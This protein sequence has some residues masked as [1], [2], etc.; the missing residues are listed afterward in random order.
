[1]ILAQK[2]FEEECLRC[3]NYL[4]PSSKDQLIEE[5]MSTY[6]GKVA[7]ELLVFKNQ[8]IHDV[9]NN[10]RVEDLKIYMFIFKQSK[11]TM[12]ILENEL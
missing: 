1:M 4:D 5:F 6:V 2:R 8:G 9:I 11:L 3:K 10:D 7:K 12:K